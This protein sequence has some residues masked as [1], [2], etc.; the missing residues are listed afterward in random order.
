[1]AG[2]VRPAR[3]ASQSGDRGIVWRFFTER[4]INPDAGR[5]VETLDGMTVHLT[6][7][8]TF[9]A[10]SDGE[11]LTDVRPWGGDLEPT[12]LIENVASAQHHPARVA[13]PHVRR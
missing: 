5:G 4:Y 13:R 2:I 11:R 3:G 10:V 8:G 9:E 6:H 7:W 12:P 1:M